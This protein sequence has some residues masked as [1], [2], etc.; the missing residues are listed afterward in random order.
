MNQNFPEI[1]ASNRDWLKFQKYLPPEKR[2]NHVYI[3]FNEPM[4]EQLTGQFLRVHMSKD[5]LEDSEDDFYKPEIYQPS[6]VREKILCPECGTPEER[7]DPNL[8]YCRNAK[9]KLQN[10]GHVSGPVRGVIEVLTFPDHVAYV[11]KREIDV[12]V[13][14]DQTVFFSDILA[15]RK[16]VEQ[17]S[18]VATEFKKETIDVPMMNACVLLLDRRYDELALIQIIRTCGIL[19]D[20]LGHKL[21]N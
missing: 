4:P 2:E 19:C 20:E 8:S 7:V 13:I 18:G 1:T 12:P 17:I 15:G 10:R 14:D 21:K 11:A 6:R 5:R 16:S 9:C 3:A